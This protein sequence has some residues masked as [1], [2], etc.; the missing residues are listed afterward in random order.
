MFFII[1]WGM[2]GEFLKMLGD[3]CTFRT[4]SDDF[5]TFFDLFRRCLGVLWG[6]LGSI[7]DRFGRILRFFEKSSKNKVVQNGPK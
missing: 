2:F 7:W 5:L 6:P 3:V 1:F 4:L